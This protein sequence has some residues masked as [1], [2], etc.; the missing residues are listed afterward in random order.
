MA[1]SRPPTIIALGGGGYSMEPDNPLLDEFVLAAAG[2]D[3]P[4]I[5]N[6]ATASGDDPE[7]VAEFHR[8]FGALGA[9]TTDL[10]LPDPEASARPGPSRASIAALLGEQ[11]VIY[12]GGGNTLSMLRIWRAYGLD[13]LLADL[14]RR[15]TVLAGV[16]AG[17]LCWFEE[18]VTDSIPGRMTPMTCLGLL[19]GSF[20]PHYDG[21]AERRPAFH[22]LVGSGTLGAGF[23]VDDSCALAFEGT[24]LA[25]IVSSV[26][27]A[28]A[29][30]VVRGESA[31]REDRLEARFLGG[32]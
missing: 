20:C 4:R 24:G 14:W 22:A 31:A 12:V 27:G 26:P 23:A 15:G 10:P 2:T 8:A 21:E 3:A 28:S 25:Q 1:T 17:G 6:L 5:A 7:Y 11:D 9:R 18:G 16:S 32:P 19:A 29:W 13:E 30:R